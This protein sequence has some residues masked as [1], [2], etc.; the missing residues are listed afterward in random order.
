MIAESFN[1]PELRSLIFK[2]SERERQKSH[3]RNDEICTL[4]YDDLPGDGKLDTILEMVLFMRRHGRYEQLK[5]F[6]K[7]DRDW[8]DWD[9]FK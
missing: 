8:I 6:L 2:I 3:G 5:K 4:S 9:V 7:V 1:E